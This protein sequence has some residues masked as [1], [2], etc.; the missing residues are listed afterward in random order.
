MQKKI[1]SKTKLPELQPST[2]RAAIIEKIAEL[3]HTL[4]AS[5]I[6]RILRDVQY[7]LTAAWKFFMGLG[8]EKQVL[9]LV[10]GFTTLPLSLARNCAY[11]IIYG[12]LP[13]EKELL[14]DLAI[15]KG[16][17]N[18]SC[19]SDLGSLATK[20]DLI[21][22]AGTRPGNSILFLKKNEISRL[23]HPRS[24]FWIITTNQLSF[25]FAK[26]T[27]H[28]IWKKTSAK[29]PT[30][31]QHETGGI[32]FQFGSARPILTR[33]AR[34]YLEEIECKPYRT[35]GLSPTVV[36]ARVA[37]SFAQSPKQTGNENAKSA[38]GRLLSED[39][40]IGASIK[41]PAQSF[42]ERF[43]EHI[44][45]T[46]LKN[47]SLEKYMISA[48]GKVLLFVSF[49]HLGEKRKLLVK[50]P[51][52]PLA[53]QKLVKNHALL[54]H[55]SLSFEIGS[56]RRSFFPQPVAAGQFE[57]QQYFIESW[58]PGKSGDVLS[59]SKSEQK[60][61]TYELFSFWI[62]IQKSYARRYFFCTETFYEMLEQ[63]LAGVFSFFE[64]RREYDGIFK[65][66]LSY[67]REKILQKEFVLSLAH[68][69]FSE[70]NI[71]LDEKTLTVKG[72]ID[73]DMAGETAFPIL[74]VF[75]YFVR[76]KKSSQN[77]SVVGLLKNML[78]KKNDD[79]RFKKVLA[80]YMES[81]AITEGDLPALVMV[82]WIYRMN[83]HLNT[84]KY[85][86]T[87][88]VRRNF[89]EPVKVFETMMQ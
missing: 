24:E 77:R 54:E 14:Q 47:G 6:K 31:K 84:L 65:R 51:L 1:T 4:P 8:I 43:L 37:R 68:G 39:I 13:E 22:S 83:G 9:V 20:F 48:G 23:I 80:L 10:D 12:L 70:K 87:S 60:R 55:F 46:D 64:K 29:K 25:G 86:D 2:S 56:T 34:A 63:P 57:N 32:R 7:E 40:V 85:M 71:I 11:A 75:H 61:L 88:F 89:T 45:D 41:E 66:M 17:S 78:E 33:K 76:A 73:W 50:L 26:E 52:N 19:I 58:L 18:Y 74:D 36:D 44:P 38:W 15:K 72:V 28:A 82:Y 53:G 42:L 3:S 16:I 79:R 49:S 5:T 27:I 81:F 35:I 67:L 30:D 21:V 69:D 62:G 59:L